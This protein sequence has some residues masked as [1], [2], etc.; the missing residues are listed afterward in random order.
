MKMSGKTEQNREDLSIAQFSTW[1]DG[2]D[3]GRSQK[4]NKTMIYKT[5]ENGAGVEEAP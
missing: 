1:G 4:Q 5:G 3:D 2:T